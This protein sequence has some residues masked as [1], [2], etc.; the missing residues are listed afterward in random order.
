VGEGSEVTIAIPTYGRDQVLLDTVAHLLTQDPRAAEILLV[1][2]TPQH[3]DATESALKAWTDQGQVRWLRLERPSITGAMNR[4][5]LEASS[6]VVLFVDD[7][8]VPAPGLVAAHSAAHARFPGAWAIAGQVLQPGEEPV[9]SPPSCTQVGLSADLGFPFDSMAVA[10]VR[11]DNGAVLEVEASWAA[12]V[13]E[14]QMM[15][16]RL[17]G[18][19][20]GCVN[21]NINQTY[22]FESAIYYEQDGS[23]YDVKLNRAAEGPGSAMYALVDSIVTKKPHPASGEEGLAVQELLDAIYKSAKLGKPIRVR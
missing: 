7:D 12:N 13:A 9:E 8:I 1:D 3:D 6:P 11:F 10:M 5:L 16:T 14:H 20:G 21:Y 18:T 19:E 22:Q 2:Q 23:Q 17:L 15:E 4:A